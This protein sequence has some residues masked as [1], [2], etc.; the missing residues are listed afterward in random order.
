[1]LSG[2]GW[3]LAVFFILGPRVYPEPWYTYGLGDL[4]G[5]TATTA[6][7]LLLIRIADPENRTNALLA[8]SNK[9]PFYEPF[10]GGGLVTALALPT[11]SFIG[12]WGSLGITGGILVLWIIYAAILAGRK[13]N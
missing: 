8:Y 11:L 13:K 3:N 2:S 5:G 10:M 6:S 1:M 7:G 4:G 9:Q 12:L